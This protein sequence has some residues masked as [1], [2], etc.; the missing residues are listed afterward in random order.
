[1][2]IPLKHISVLLEPFLEYIPSKEIGVYLDVTAGG[3]GHLGALLNNK[4]KW[5]A[6]AWDRDPLAITRIEAH[7]QS[8]SIEKSRWSFEQ[9][10]FS[11]GTQ[12]KFDYILA[13]LGISSFQIDDP[14]RGMSFHSD[15]PI[16]FRMNPSEGKNFSEWFQD[17]SEADLEEILDL[18]GEEAK[19]KKIASI[20]KSWNVTTLKSAKDW[21]NKISETLP[22]G[23][24]SKRHP[25]TRI[26]Q[27]FRIAINDEMG[28][29]RKLLKW[30]PTA[31][32]E[33][34]RLAIISFHSLE[35]R[36]VKKEFNKLAQD[37]EYKVLT[38]KPILPNDEELTFNPRSRSAKIRVLERNK[39]S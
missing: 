33:S 15:S 38:P 5:L 10:K 39:G 8:L 30:A 3:G 21:A 19:S 9:K 34:G 35:D 18:Y 24:E 4:K 7:L 1:M 31:L 26:F 32:N 16:D 28:E 17:Q 13:D 27:A 2:T 20:I 29:L 11:Q 37:E 23:G 22:Y 6:E 25:A 12:K 14:Q 36:F